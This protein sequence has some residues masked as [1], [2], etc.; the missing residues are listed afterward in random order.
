MKH[1]HPPTGLTMVRQMAYKQAPN[2]DWLLA[3]I[4]LLTT[5]EQTF[6]RKAKVA[7]AAFNFRA[8][9]GS[10][11]LS[12]EPVGNAKACVSGV[13]EW[14]NNERA[15]IVKTICD[16]LSTCFLGLSE[17]CRKAFNH[18]RGIV[19]RCSCNEDL[20]LDDLIPA[21]GYCI[22]TALNEKQIPAVSNILERIHR[23]L[24]KR[25]DYVQTLCAS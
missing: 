17:E 3:R 25:V 21:F 15:T 18:H 8:D 12:H 4:S 23:K 11:W 13:I 6:K 24:C 1:C 20:K 14:R 10:L 9:G 16:K 5:D 2:S 7:V 22:D 19:E